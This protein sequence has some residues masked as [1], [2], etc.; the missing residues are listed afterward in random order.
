MDNTNKPICPI[1]FL[2]KYADIEITKGNLPHWSQNAATYFV[3]FRTADSIPQVK[4]KK[5]I[6]QRN[7]WLARHPLPLTQVETR[8]FHRLFTTQLER[9]LDNQYGECLL[10]N[11]LLKNIVKNSLE[12]F[13]NCRYSLD[14]FVVMPNH[15]HAIVT[16]H[17]NHKLRDIVSSW[18]S[19]TANKINRVTHRNGH[20]WQKESFDHIIRNENQLER[21]RDYIKRHSA[22]E[23]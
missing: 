15:V 10:S 16:P 21:I 8:E 6:N 2:D 9:W 12:Y 13:N 5:W 17:D 18:K 11:P 23:K 1:R 7:Q 20:F 19:F 4:L 22:F 14:T 3:T